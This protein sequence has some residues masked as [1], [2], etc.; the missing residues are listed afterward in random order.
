MATVP[1]PHRYQVNA[2]SGP[3]GDVV[4]LGDGLRALRSQAPR[5]FGGPGDRWSPETLLVGAVADCFALTF[6]VVARAARLSWQSLECEADGTLDRVDRVPQFTAFRI[7]AYLT[8]PCGT[9]VEEARRVLARAK[10]HCLVSHSLKAP[11]VFE[12]NVDVV[13][14]AGAT[15]V[16]AT[17]AQ[18]GGSAA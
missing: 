2:T 5:P 1:L 12:A 7:R 8:I 13:E 18:S 14:T 9:S 11:C 16:A 6:R 4:L 15:P 3:E 17:S 10:E